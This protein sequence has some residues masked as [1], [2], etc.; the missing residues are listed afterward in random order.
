M[1]VMA[2]SIALTAGLVAWQ[3]HVAKTTGNRVVKAFGMEAFERGRFREKADALFDNSLRYMTASSG[4]WQDFE[5]TDKNE[6]GYGMPRDLRKT[7]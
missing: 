3:R 5:P 4:G 1:V 7:S 6:R 2:I